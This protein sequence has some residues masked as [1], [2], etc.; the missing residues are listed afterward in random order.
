MTRTHSL[1]S[2]RN[3]GIL[4]HIDAGK[5]TT[6]ERILY[7][8]GRTYKIG[9][10]HDGTAVMDW[11]SQEQERGI[12]ITSAATSC[13]WKDTTINIIDTP[14]HVDF[15]V[16]V[17]RSLRILDG[18]I[19]L[20]DAKSGVEPQ[21]E[22]VWRQANKHHVPRIVFINKMDIVG[23]DFFR[24][25]KMIDENLKGNPLILQL[26]IGAESDF[27]GVISLVDMKAIYNS[28]DKGEHLIYEEIPN[29]YID[30]ATSYRNRLI[31]TLAD[32]DDDLMV[33]YLDNQ[34]IPATLLKET[35]RK[36]CLEGKVTPLLCGAAYRNK[37]VQCLL[38][39]IVDYLPCPI[40]LDD[41]IG[42]TPK[43]LETTRPASDQAPFSALVFKIASDPYVGKLVYFRVY[44][45]ALKAGSTIYN[46]SKDQKVK[47]SKLLRMHADKRQELP[48][49]Y[50]G[51][52]V[53]TIGLKSISTGDT[54]SDQNAPILL[55]SMS[56]PTPVIS[57]AI[58][59]KTPGDFDKMTHTLD[60]LTE[61]D[62]TLNTYVEPETGQRIISGMGELHLEV[63]LDRIKREFNLNINAGKPQVTY[64]ESITKEANIDYDLSKQMDL[65]GM[66]AHIKLKVKPNPRGIGHTFNSSVSSKKLPK[67]YLEAC[68]EGIFK[69]LHS[70]V[71]GGYEVIDTHIELYDASYNEDNSNEICFKM[72]G[73]NA[74]TEALKQANSVKL[75]PIFKVEI[76]SPENYA[77]DIIND[78]NKRKGLIE[79]IDTRDND[80]IIYAK[81]PLSNLFGYATDLRSMTQGRGHYDMIFDHFDSVK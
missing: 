45:G 75:E 51:D 39:A 47:I 70:G 19:V 61:E 34:P 69:S 43:G 73:S 63:I 55:E 38:D 77:G 17:E 64:K 15:T 33:L 28:G 41:V 68:K 40:D 59:P 53:A 50:T 71:I 23:A 2:T 9:E 13:Q 81:I 5:T 62:P 54:L 24:S 66:Y 44:S 74:I 57:V 30:Q 58:E 37:G 27:D 46:T 78:I 42:H 32:Y 36:A 35:I 21:T 20:L 72:A 49:V 14:G 4:A 18:A 56:F 8:S 25:L 52:I 7:Y 16:E 65:K 26:P 48:A 76:T 6:T 31:E 79:R 29:T 10:V 67:I 1:K 12:T 60:Q 3:I 22:A 80:Q 11:M